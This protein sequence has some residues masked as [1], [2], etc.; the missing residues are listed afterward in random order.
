M[1]RRQFLSSTAMLMGSTAV[2]SFL[3][4]V[5]LAQETPVSGGTLIWGH[6]ETVQNLDMHQTGTASTNR[7]LQNVHNSIVTVDANLSVIP[8]LA[9]SFEESADG[10]TYTFKLRPGVKFHDGKT[11]TS[12]DVKYSFERCKDPATGAVNFEVFNNVAAIET[13]DDLTV[14]VKMSGVNAPFLSRLAENGAG[15][16]MPEGSGDK[17]GTTPIGAGPFKF[18][19]YEAG[20][21]VELARF[22]D[23]WDGPAYLEKV[24][25][26]EITE[27]TVRLT[28]LR[29]GELHMINDIPA[30]RM[31]EI[32]ADTKF[33][34][35][36]WFPL[37]WDFVNLNHDFEPFKDPKVRMAMDLIIDKEMLLQGALWGQ[38][39]TTASPS[40]PTSAS[41]N[42]ALANRPQD[43]EKAVALL[44]E[45][46]YGPGQLKV[47][48]KA[49]TNYPYHIEAAQIMVE[50]FKAA[51]V[52]MTIEQLT[53]ADW[54]SQ[55]WVNKDF[56]ISMMNFFTLWEP[57]FLYYSLWHSTG[58]FNYRH[59]SD[60]VIDDLVTKARVTV[61]PAAR[62]DIYKQVQ[63]R[64]FDE[65]HDIILWFRN[66]SIAAQTTVN[67][68]DTIVHPNGSNLNFHK[69]WL[70][71]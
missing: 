34:T 11:M 27:P 49:T 5:S 38:G 17:Q 44:A 42:S 51:G 31:D 69:V 16:I 10:L 60:P 13:P 14:I 58:A 43:I 32:K 28:G 70:K 35:V 54:L 15:V 6:S 3:P 22:D 41:Y 52:D 33:Q 46:G 64:V 40:Y 4:G 53:W 39:R 67:G 55:V 59:I 56:Q 65:T 50:W 9:E 26:R 24:I 63:Q 36:T 8:M 62:A 57:D 45:A 61:D 66:G 29:T 1:K 2:F 48:F 71:A 19:S 18:V 30:D 37:N 7:V 12:A 68:L 25:A 23:Y 21:Q 20:H 47:V